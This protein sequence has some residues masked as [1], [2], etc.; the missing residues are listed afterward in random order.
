MT[1]KKEEIK[2]HKGVSRREFIAGTVGGVVVGAVVGAATGSLGF[3]KII[4]QT[5]TE[6]QTKNV[7]ATQ[8]ATQTTTATTTATTTVSPGLPASWDYETDIIIVGFGGAGGAAALMASAAGAKVMLL[9]KL[10]APGGSTAMS[11]GAFA[12][13]GTILQTAKGITDT[14]QKM[15]D[16]WSK[17]GMGM[18]DPDALMAYCQ[19]SADTW[20]WLANIIGNQIGVTDVTKY[21][22]LWEAPQFSGSAFVTPSDVVPRFSAFLGSTPTLPSYGNGEFQAVYNAIKKDPNITVMLSTSVVSL[23]TRN[24]QVVGVQ[25]KVSGTP[26][27]FKAKRAVVIS[28]GSFARNDDMAHR[29][30]QMVYYGVKGNSPGNTGEG[31]AMAQV[32]GADLM[33][34]FGDMSHPRAVSGKTLNVNTS[35]FVNNRGQRFVNES[36]MSIPASQL[37]P[38]YVPSGWTGYYAGFAI[39]N[40][41]QMQ[42]WAVFDSAGKGT[43]SLDPPVVTA[44]SIQD[45]AKAMGVNAAALTATVN[46]WNA[47]ATKQAD[48]LYGRPNNFMQ[49]STAP[50]YA[51]P[52][53]W[54]CDDSWGGLRINGKTQVLDSTAKPISHLYAAGAT[55]GGICGP[56]Y[57]HSGGAVGSAYTMGRIAGKNAAAET[58]WS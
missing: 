1:E 11:H 57:Q 32:V 21:P 51:A 20:L 5:E 9:E 37:S 24:G 28:T 49:I 31:I 29:L 25:A 8:T 15:Y 30:S 40:Q 42:A 10:D 12:A 52:L 39:Y 53:N 7:T 27:S 54:T 33:G 58:P 6:T 50:F 41:D 18:T 14:P 19:N 43:N 45:L 3:P 26:K 47:D 17:A 23:F 34:P 48:T 36:T 44:S 46:Q 22:T 35:I 56:F 55:T 38:A 16:F 2:T 4:T 13:A